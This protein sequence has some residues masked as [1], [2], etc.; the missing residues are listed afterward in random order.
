MVSNLRSVLNAAR[1]PTSKL[2]AEVLSQVF[3][4]LRAPEIPTQHYP[5]EDMW[6]T[7]NE[8]LATVSLVCRYW[9]QAAIGAKELW[10]HIAAVDLPDFKRLRLMFELFLARSGPYPLSL[11]IPRGDDYDHY[12]YT[13]AVMEPFVHRLQTLTVG[14]PG[15]DPSEYQFFSRPA[16]LLEEL[17]MVCLPEVKTLPRLFEGSTPCLRSLDLVGCIP[18]SVNRFYNLS[19][20]A[21]GPSNIKDFDDLLLMLEDS[22]G[23]EHLYLQ[24]GLT[25]TSEEPYVAVL[26]RSAKLPYL[27]TF[28]LSRFTV[29]E[30]CTLFL[31]LGLPQHSLA[32]RF[33]D[34]RSEDLNFSHIY[35]P[36]FLRTCPCSPPPV[37]R[38]ILHNFPAPSTRLV[39]TR[40]P[41]YNGIPTARISPPRRLC[42]TSPKALSTRSKNYGSHHM[43]AAQTSRSRSRL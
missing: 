3:A 7:L 21:L 41:L 30:I 10:T 33:V 19:T 37:S 14:Q 8:S 42:V 38:S 13:F 29:E 34:I 31:S 20:L 17:K 43:Q 32:M 23:L 12:S 39:T 6:P 36:I 40:Q 18:D 24:Q 27:K 35:P 2:P 15:V 5:L 22:P 26:N 16:P 11:T 1:S 28:S 25:R 9:R 4:C